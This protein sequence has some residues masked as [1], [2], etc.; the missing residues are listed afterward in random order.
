MVPGT[1]AGATGPSS[2]TWLLR[3]TRASS[4]LRDLKSH[5]F[6]RPR[7]SV[8]VDKAEP[9]CPFAIWSWKLQRRS[10]PPY[11]IDQ[12]SHHPTC[13]QEEEQRSHLLAGRQQVTLSKNTGNGREKRGYLYLELFSTPLYYVLGWSHQSTLCVPGRG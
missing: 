4:Q 10:L 2:D 11:C 6:H 3:G 12:S 8:L 7:N 9:A 13:L 1:S 5:F